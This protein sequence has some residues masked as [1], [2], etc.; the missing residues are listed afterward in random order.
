MLGGVV[1]V[2]DA[3]RAV[4]V[5]AGQFPDPGRAVSQK[6]HDFG[7]GHPPAQGLAAHGRAGAVTAD[8][9]DL[10][11]G[12]IVHRSLSA[13]PLGHP[14][15]HA[16][17]H[18]LNLPRVDFQPQVGQQTLGPKLTQEGG[19]FGEA[20]CQKRRN[21]SFTTSLCWSQVSCSV[22]EAK[23]AASSI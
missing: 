7:P 19:R 8:T 10:S 4:E 12:G 6:H 22:R 23:R 16:F 3:H 13:T 1:E 18:A 14:G 9:E 15:A 21:F 11:G 20:R 17:D 2:Q 5:N